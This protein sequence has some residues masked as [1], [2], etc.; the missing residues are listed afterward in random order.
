MGRSA[1]IPLQAGVALTVTRVETDTPVGCVNSTFISLLTDSV[2]RRDGEIITVLVTALP[3]AGRYWMLT[4]QDSAVSGF[5]SVR[6][7]LK[8]PP[9][10]PSAKYQVLLTGPG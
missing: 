1:T 3:V 6:Y 10:K 7:S 4:E 2:R 9:T 8:P 5:S